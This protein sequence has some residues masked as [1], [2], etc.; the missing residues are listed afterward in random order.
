MLKRRDLYHIATDRKG[1]YIAS[2]RERK[3]IAFAIANISPNKIASVNTDAVLVKKR[4]Q[5]LQFEVNPKV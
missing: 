2:S 3:Y 1:G 4:G 5:R